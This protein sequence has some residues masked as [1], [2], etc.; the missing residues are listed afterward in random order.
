ML[1]VCDVPADRWV[2]SRW[3]GS[4]LQKRV[5]ASLRGEMFAQALL[6]RQ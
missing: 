6:V 1:S 5:T 3:E 2:F 4:E